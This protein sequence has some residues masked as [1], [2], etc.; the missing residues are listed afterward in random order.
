M[1]DTV[2]VRLDVGTEVEEY[3]RSLGAEIY[4]VA[5]A[6]K[7]EE[8]FPKKPSPSKFVEGAKSVIIVGMPFSREIID[9]VAKPWLAEIHRKGA[10]MAALDSQTVQRPPAG[11][12]RYYLGPENAMLSHEVALIAYKVALKL[13]RD[14]HKAFYLPNVQTEPRFKTAPFYFMPAMY[15]AG[16][17]QLGM[18]CAIITPEYG[19]RIRV[20]AI[21]TDL[22]LPAGEP[23][24]EKLYP[25][26]KTCLECVR[27]CPSKAI[28]GRY[29]KNVFKCSNYGCSSTC[30]SVC[31]VG[32]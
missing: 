30:L 22:E 25:G 29:W 5:S 20:T 14:G 21:I 2:D 4:G 11:A 31:P 17:G 18:N 3:A 26:C 27:R 13:R 6:D 9:T 23:M 10:D 19:P 15:V 12:E 7:Y 8:L 28:D 1:V 24:A 32:D 16:M